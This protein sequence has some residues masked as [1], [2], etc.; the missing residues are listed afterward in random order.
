MLIALVSTAWAVNIVVTFFSDSY[1]PDPSINA[2]FSGVIGAFMA[3]G[4]GDDK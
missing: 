2:L 3:T 1:S 4:R